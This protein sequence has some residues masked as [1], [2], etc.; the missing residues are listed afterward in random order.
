MGAPVNLEINPDVDS[1]S[2]I[3][4]VVFECKTRNIDLI[5]DEDLRN[6]GSYS[7]GMESMDR[8][9]MTQLVS[10]NLCIATMAEHFSK[11]YTLR[12]VHAQDVLKIYEFTQHHLNRWVSFLGGTSLNGGGA[13]IDDLI[14]LDLYCTSVYEQ[15]K[16]Y[17]E[18]KLTSIEQRFGNARS[19]GAIKGMFF[20]EQDSRDEIERKITVHRK[21]FSEL[22]R[23]VQMK[24]SMGFEGIQM[25]HL[26]G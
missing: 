13:P 11:G 15:A 17:D 25:P 8:D 21:G 10:A 18:A 9:N 14:K 5:T 7:T 16:F 23:E 19:F 3:F 20:G 4:D 6:F 12:Y 22:F 24:K 1:G 2:Y 26:N